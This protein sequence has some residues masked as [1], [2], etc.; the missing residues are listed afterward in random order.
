MKLSRP[1]GKSAAQRFNTHSTLLIL[2]ALAA[3][4]SPSRACG[5][6]FPADLLGDRAATL[7][8]LPEGS[9]AFEVLRLVEKP[10]W[11]VLEHADW[12]QP[13]SQVTQ[14]SIE[15]D[16]WGDRYERIDALRKAESAAAAYEQ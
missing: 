6:F 3:V 14:D 13:Y 1:W 5:P 10:R 9:F 11:T 16:W 15:R 4:A 8:K 7:G 12:L 2:L